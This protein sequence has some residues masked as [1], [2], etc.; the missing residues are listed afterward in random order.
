MRHSQRLVSTAIFTALLSACGSGSDST[1]LPGANGARS[2]LPAVTPNYAPG[3]PFMAD[4]VNPVGHINSGQ[5]TGMHH[6]GPVGPSERLSEA[7]LV[8][9]VFKT[10]LKELKSKGDWNDMWFLMKPRKTINY[11][12]TLPSTGNTDGGIDWGWLYLNLNL[13]PEASPA[14][15]QVQ[16]CQYDLDR[17]GLRLLA[18]PAYPEGQLEELQEQYGD[19]LGQELKVMVILKC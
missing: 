2:P 6:A 7:S 9:Q 14:P 10:I 12:S 1:Q 17:V 15:T 3:N 16:V 5:T 18:S 19:E 8:I 11:P 13:G 4:S